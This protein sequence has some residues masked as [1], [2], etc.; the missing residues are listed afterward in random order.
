MSTVASP[1]G[2]L[3]TAEEFA[4]RPDPGFP[5][6]LKRGRVIKMPPPRARHGQVCN[7]IGRLLGN[8][9]DEHNLGHVLSN[10]S[11]VIT[12]RAPD[13]VRGPDISYY[14]YEKLPK[15]PLP[16]TYPSVA[17]DLV[18]EVL[19]PDDRWVRV[20]EKVSE[21]LVAGVP[22]VLVL[23]PEE[24]TMHIHHADRPS[25]I[26]SADEELSLPETMPDLRVR[27]GEFFA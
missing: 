4:Q 16:Q 18:A 3:L 8:H 1:T 25:R 23:D 26:L 9:A 11:G 14:S 15:G 12:E 17:P 2:Q 10:D 21:Y 7:K 5:E 6:E 22:V 24:E 19:S 27:V 13:S 20:L